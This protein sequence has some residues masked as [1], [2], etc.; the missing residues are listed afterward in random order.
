MRATFIAA[1]V[2][3][4][5]GVTAQSQPVELFGPDR[6][7]TLIEEG[8]V[9]DTYTS[10]GYIFTVTRDKLFTGGLPG[11]EPIGRDLDI[12][13]P[14]GLEAQALSVLPP[15]VGDN[16]ARIEI[17]RV[18][19]EPFDLNAFT[20]MML[21]TQTNPIETLY[22]IMPIYNDEDAFDEPIRFYG[23]G[24]YG[25]TFHYDQTSVPTNTSLFVGYHAYKIK[26]L[27]DFALISLVVDGPACPA[28]LNTDGAIDF[29]DVSA[30]LSAFNAMDPLADFTGDGMFD[31]F[32]VSAFLTAFT[33][34]C[35]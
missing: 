6:S 24:H 8:E 34:G 11:G 12:E 35:P 25:D 13:L 22:E 23:T 7:F 31:F 2:L 19:G 5:F 16:K 14:Q 4:L 17:S 27:L 33:A 10:N 21:W 28:D 26:F 32:D 3:S 9:W 18:D 30:F 29:F 15:S 1:A 20:M